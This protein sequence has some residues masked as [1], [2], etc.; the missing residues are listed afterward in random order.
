MQ[1]YKPVECFSVGDIIEALKGLPS[2]MPCKISFSDSVDVVVFNE[3]DHDE[4]VTFEDGGDW[5]R[6]DDFEE[7]EE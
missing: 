3:G 5:S 2:D 1:K 6:D 4:H 7:D